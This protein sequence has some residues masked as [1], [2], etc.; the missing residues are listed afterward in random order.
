MRLTVPAGP[1]SGLN[2]ASLFAYFFVLLGLLPAICCDFKLVFGG[3][4]DP[5]PLQKKQLASQS[6]H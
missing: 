3:F 1:H 4:S 6:M 5:S 2:A